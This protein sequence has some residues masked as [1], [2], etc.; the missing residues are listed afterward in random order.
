MN[1]LFEEKRTL[2]LLLLSLIFLG[3]LA[4]YLFFI[5][6][7]SGELR[8]AKNTSVSLEADIDVFEAKNSPELSKKDIDTLLLQKKVPLKPEL[9][10]LLL[11]FQE[12]EQTSGSRIDEVEFEYDGSEPEF[13]LGQEEEKESG[14]NAEDQENSSDEDT[15][16]ESQEDSAIEENADENTEDSTKPEKLHLVTAKLTVLS[17]DHEHFMKFI[18]EIEALKRVTRVDKLEFFK[19]AEKELEFQEN[20]NE[21]MAFTIH[22]TTFYYGK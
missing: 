10:K 21:T 7:L 6:P 14:E 22:V 12:I 18:K 16:G 1:N 11:T 5:Q 4:V 2:F 20:P 19:P 17:P 9:E 15:D 13:D 3:L 8:T